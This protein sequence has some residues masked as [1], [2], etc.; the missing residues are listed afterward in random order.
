M[1]A[2][3]QRQVGSIASVYRTLCH[4]Q[5][6]QCLELADKLPRSL[7][8]LKML[9]CKIA[10]KSATLFTKA[11]LV[12]KFIII[13]QFLLIACPL[14]KGQLDYLSCLAIVA[15]IATQTTRIK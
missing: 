11:G 4:L 2:K 15:R 10:T 7:L 9:N 8:K 1:F 6:G 3:Y 14:L 13:R 5:K 12:C